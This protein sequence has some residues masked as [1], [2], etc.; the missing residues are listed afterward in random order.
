MKW[1]DFAKKVDGYDKQNTPE[2][3]EKNTN[4]LIERTKKQIFE[5][6][7]IKI[8][9]EHQKKYPQEEW[10]KVNFTPSRFNNAIETKPNNYKNLKD[11]F[12]WA[13]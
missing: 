5:G 10:W 13:F 9:L 8:E 1:L 6:Q 2:K 12:G 11:D 4:K 3:L 7:I